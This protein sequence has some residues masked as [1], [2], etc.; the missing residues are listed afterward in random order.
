MKFRLLEPCR[1][2]TVGLTCHHYCCLTR[3]CDQRILFDNNNNNNNNCPTLH[4]LRRGR[5][6]GRCRVMMSE[7]RVVRLD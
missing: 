2:F 5:T 4:T 6:E 3:F 7:E 1:T